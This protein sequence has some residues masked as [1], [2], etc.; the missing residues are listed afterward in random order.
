MISTF[1][2]GAPVSYS[3]AP[4]SYYGA[5][6]SYSGAPVSY[7]GAPVSYSGAPVSY[8]GAHV[9]YSGAP[10]SFVLF[11]ILRALFVFLCFFIWSLYC[12]QRTSINY[13]VPDLSLCL[14]VL[15]HRA[16]LDRAA[17]PSA[18]CFCFIYLRWIIAYVLQ[19]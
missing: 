17:H 15:K 10:V 13:P 4:V 2:S 1:Y 16:P 19:F 8:P 3:G 6:V 18:N 11:N 5:P 7:S 12:L 14:G 9:R